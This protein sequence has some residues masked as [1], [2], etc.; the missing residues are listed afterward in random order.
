MFM[1][2][3]V[4]R[5]SHAR[6][7]VVLGEISRDKPQAKF[8]K[9]VV[10]LVCLPANYRINRRL[11][12]QRLAKV[13]EA[14]DSL[15]YNRLTLKKGAKLG[16][17]AC[18]ISYSYALEAV[19]WLGL[20]DK[21]SMLK[22]G[23]PYP[24]P[25]KMTKQFLKAVPEIL[26]VEEL[27][28]FVE[29]GVKVIAEEAGIIARIHGKDLISLAG[30][31]STRQVTEALSKLTGVK[32]PVD[33]AR[34][35]KLR[36]E[37]AA[38]LPVRPPTV[39]AGCPHRA[40][41]YAIN[42]A[43]QNYKKETGIEPVLSGDI[44]CYSLGANPPLNSADVCTG[45]GGGFG[46]ANGLAHALNAPVVAHLGDSTF[47]HSGI[48]PMLNAVYN[49]ANIT[50]VVLD[51]STTGMT[52]FQPHPGAPGAGGTP[53]MIEDLA[54]ASGVKF[55]EVVD[56]F[57]VPK[58]ISTLESAIRYEGPS[59]IVSRGLCNILDQREKRKQGV[60]T[61]PYK[62]DQE[63]CKQCKLCINRLG[64]PALIMEGDKVVID[65]TQCSGCGVCAQVC[66]FDAIIPESDE[67]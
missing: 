47:F 38:Q 25:E 10:K 29:D 22:I 26:V 43:C 5:I 4:T 36:D 2:R 42:V 34:L 16:I 50:M 65:A 61:V 63:K 51:N 67:K 35:D 7:D 19:R 55:V 28:P 49:K 1:L 60:K 37:T 58:L 17:I 45:M 20:E 27:E 59:V 21:V 54:R 40:S 53:I 56:T 52:G 48:P 41:F 62:V 44:G 15:P 3:S 57:D 23:M 46:I 18:G 6:S 11:M 12:V 66:K 32:P 14:A 24:L 9:D 64:C 8:V 31:L 13:K 39:C 33:F 30:E